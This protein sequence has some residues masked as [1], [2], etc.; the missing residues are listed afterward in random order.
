ML[1]GETPEV[2]HDMLS[3]VIHFPPKHH[4][5]H[6]YY[7]I[8]HFVVFSPNTP[9]EKEDIDN[10]TRAKIALSTVTVAVHNTHCQ[11]PFFVQVIIGC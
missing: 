9:N 6:D 8:N 11:V 7:G 5:I 1:S 10:E 4:P 2:F 3:P